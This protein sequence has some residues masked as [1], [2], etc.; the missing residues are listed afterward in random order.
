VSGF[1]GSSLALY[2]NRLTKD[3][4][5]I[6]I[7]REKIDTADLARVKFYHQDINDPLPDIKNIHTVIHLAAQAGVRES[8]EQFDK[9]VQDNIIGTWNIIEKCISTWKPKKFIFASSSSIYGDCS[10]KAK[11]TDTLKPVSLYGFTKVACEK[12]IETYKN[13]GLLDE[14][15]C[16][17]LRFF[18]VY[19]PRQ[20]SGLA[21]ANFIDWILHDEPITVYGN[22]TQ[23]RDFLF[24]DDLCEAIKLLIDN[25]MNIPYNTHEIFN[26]ASNKPYSL[27]EVIYYISTLLKKTVEI[28]YQPRNRYDV[29]NTSADISKIQHF[30]N[31]SPG[32]KLD[33]GIRRQIDYAKLKL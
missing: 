26:V 1:I 13:N 32:T 12:L 24:I 10:E 23:K 7:D 4:Q 20:R 16:I 17:S 15:E 3:Y 6:G 8:Q 33:D 19:G 2:L 30:I 28:D 5:I 11:E 14:T 9:F 25:P 27:N 21:I 29:L 22:G 18:T 31:W